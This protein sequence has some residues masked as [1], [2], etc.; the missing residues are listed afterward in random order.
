[1]N[2]LFFLFA[3]L[4]AVQAQA[5][6][7]PLAIGT[8][9][10]GKTLVVA[11]DVTINDPTSA[12][13]I[14]NQGVI[15]GT[16]FASVSTNTTTT[17]VVSSNANLSALT[18]SPGALSPPFA[19]SITAYSASVPNSV[20]AVALTPTAEQ[21]NATITVNGTAVSSG[22]SINVPLAVCANT[23]SVSVTA[24][25]GV[26]TKLYAL[27]I[28]RQTPP[29][30]LTA[31]S[32][33]SCT[34]TTVTLTATPGFANY[35]FSAGAVQVGGQASNVASVTAAGLYSVTATATGG[36][37]ATA[38]ASVSPGPDLT[39]ILYARP[40]PQYSTTPMTVVVD[41][42]ELNG[43]TATGSFTLKL[44][45]DA[46][47]S[48]SWPASATLIDNRSVQNSQWSFDGSSDP[49]YYLLTS[50]QPVAGGGVLSVGLEGVLTPGA[51]TGQLPVS[52]ILLS[53]GSG[54]VCER[55]VN[56]NA[57]ADKIEYFQQ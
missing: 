56:N 53:G 10:A 57:D 9:P 2:R 55:K 14:T 22:S 6:L 51:T 38:T 25:D 33:L 15:S 52:G 48:L 54:G 19:A 29:L 7:N 36:C 39:P 35:S 16:N 27:T 45:K 5:Q 8:I 13:A 32:P 34:A 42:L 50:S 46:T 40:S 43:I 23:I 12:T 37:S 11:Y 18:I 26:T 28:T 30:T 17:P 1:M 24:Q 4:T 44:T 21:P 41:V 49:S 47:I 31:S 20:S 3:L